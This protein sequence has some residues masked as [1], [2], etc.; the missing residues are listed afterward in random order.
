MALHF[1]VVKQVCWLVMV[2]YEMYICLEGRT[3]S[4]GRKQSLFLTRQL[5]CYVF[6]IIACGFLQ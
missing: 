3:V 1:A 5:K 2:T 4:Q 6:G